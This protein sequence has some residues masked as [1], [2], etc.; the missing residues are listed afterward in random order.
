MPKVALFH[1][2]VKNRLFSWLK[3]DHQRSKGV[4]LINVLIISEEHLIKVV[5]KEQVFIV[6]GLRLQKRHER[7]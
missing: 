6:L 2:Q 5:S 3:F 7:I 1:E 4:K